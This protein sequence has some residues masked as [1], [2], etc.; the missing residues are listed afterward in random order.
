MKRQMRKM[1]MATLIFALVVLGGCT[2]KTDEIYQNSIQKGLD[3]VA[4]ENYSKAEGFFETALDAKKGDE[5]AKAYLHQVQLILKAE[6]LE[7]KSNWEDEIPLLEQSIKVK[8]GSKVIA[9][10]SKE[11]IEELNAKVEKQKTFSAMLANAKKLNESGDYQTSNQKVQTL[12]NE[13]LT[14]FLEMKDEATKLKESNDAAIKEAEIAQ[15][16]KEAEAKAR[17]AAAEQAKKEA[18]AKAAAETKAK[19]NDPYTWASGVKEKFENAML[20]N[21]YADS[22]DTI[23]YKKLQVANNEGFYEVYANW[24]GEFRYIVVVNVK[25]GWYHG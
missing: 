11:K 10:K 7:K 12:L 6:D 20:E 3:A 2:S 23:V 17:A 9:S 15:A 5:T 24:D 25:T 19:A 22:I 14:E 13:D 21:G 16:K 4:E 18:Q 8:K 1:A